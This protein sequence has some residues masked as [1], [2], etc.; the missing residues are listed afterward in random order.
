MAISIRT[1]G[2]RAVGVNA[3]SGWLHCELRALWRYLLASVG[4]E[5]IDMPGHYHV[6]SYCITTGCRTFGC[7]MYAA[8]I[9]GASVHMS[10]AREKS[11]DTLGMIVGLFNNVS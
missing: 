11:H 5:R 2:C 7:Q 1:V 10:Q 3:R 4:L 8:L 9:E 6:W